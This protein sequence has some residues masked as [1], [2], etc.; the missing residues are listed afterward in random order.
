MAKAPVGS[1]STWYSSNDIFMSYYNNVMRVFSGLL[2]SLVSILY[3]FYSG[4]KSIM[5][6]RVDNENKGKGNRHSMQTI[7]S[8]SE[9]DD[10]I[11][12]TIGV[13]AKDVTRTQTGRNVNEVISEDE[14]KVMFV[15]EEPN[16]EEIKEAFDVFDSNG[17][18]LIDEVELHVVLCR[19][20][21]MKS[22]EGVERCRKMISVFDRNGDEVID[23][24]EFVKFMESCLC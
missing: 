14:F 15:V 23:F 11:T 6:P 5:H 8:M 7:L 4:K 20:G 10:V 1:S 19:L 16:L 22:G 9:L 21:L 13:R 3:T 17:D 24:N 18:G 2:R 12:S